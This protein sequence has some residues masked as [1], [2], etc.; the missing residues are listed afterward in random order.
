MDLGDFTQ[1]AFVATIT[2]VMGR[3]G[4][5]FARLIDRRAGRQPALSDEAAERLRTLED[6]QL[7]LRQELAE[8]QERQDFTERA[9]LQEQRPRPEIAAERLATPD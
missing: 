2:L 9:L 6:E 1:L 3:I 4:W 7:A 8:L 5:S